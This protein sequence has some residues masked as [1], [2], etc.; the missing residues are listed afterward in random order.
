MH[1][2]KKLQRLTSI[3][4]MLC[5]LVLAAS[6]VRGAEPVQIKVEGLKGKELTN[7]EASLILPAGLVREGKVDE[8]WLERFASTDA[9]DLNSSRSRDAVS[10]D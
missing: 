9:P 4:A 10:R 5:S 7:V 8:L 2:G 3:C 6:T 1:V